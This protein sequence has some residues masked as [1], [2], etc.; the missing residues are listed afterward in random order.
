MIQVNRDTIGGSLNGHELL[1]FVAEIAKGVRISGSTEEG[2]AMD[3]LQNHL[4]ELGFKTNR[5]SGETLI[6]FPVTSKLEVLDPERFG[7]PSNGY[8]LT[9]ST[10]EG[11]VTGELIDVGHGSEAELAA[12]DLRGK[13][14]VSVGLASAEKALHIDRTGAIAHVHINEN[15]IHEMCISP[16]WGAPTPAT[17]GL[18]PKTPAI[19]V[20][21][22]DSGRLLQLMRTSKVIAHVTTDTYRDWRP[23]PTLTADL[24]GN[25][26]DLFVLFSG[27]L[28][29]WHLG[30]MDDAAANAAQLAV[31]GLLASRRSSLRRGVRL[32]FWSGHSHGRYSGSTWYADHAPQDLYDRCVCDA[33]ST[34]SERRAQPTLAKR[35]RWP[36]R[37][38]LQP[39]LSRPPAVRNSSTSG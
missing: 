16:V 19:A 3:Y 36:R 7:I 12:H 31:A 18:L 6:G 22:K 24:A 8:S 27:H 29:S 32:A 33:M 9:P 2:E 14:A 26:Q 21:D 34:H 30:A 25:D 4:D 38:V 11:G 17:L 13:I 35:P 37:T 28:D 10:P 15:E 1:K 23:T 20:C 39:R 5:Y